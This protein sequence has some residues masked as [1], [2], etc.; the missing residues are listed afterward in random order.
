VPD[1]ILGEVIAA[2]IVMREGA[3]LDARRVQAHCRDRL[4]T[5]M[6]PKTVHFAESLPK[7]ASGK[8][9]RYLLKGPQ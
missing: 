5:Y 4:A 1:E 2:H 6:I 9:Q 3:V 7:T 8:V